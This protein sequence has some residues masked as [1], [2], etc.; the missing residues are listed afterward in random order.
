M[1]RQTALL[2]VQGDYNDAEYEIIEQEMD[3][4]QRKHDAVD[5]YIIVLRKEDSTHWMIDFTMSDRSGLEE[6][7]VYVYQ[8]EKSEVKTVKWV[9]GGKK[10]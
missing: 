3:D 4:G 2:I 5:Y 6:G 10:K 1:N 7:S 8:V 9:A